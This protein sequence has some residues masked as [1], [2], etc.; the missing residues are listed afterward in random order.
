M[1]ERRTDERR[2][3]VKAGKI[4]W[5]KGSSVLDCTVRNV[6]K[7][8]AMLEVLNGLTVPEEF[9]LR[10]NNNVE[11]QRCIVVW[12]KLDRVSVKFEP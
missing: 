8:G 11:R 7:T 5:N 1:A 2:R 6:S 3:V 4:V 9:E 10:W 12:R